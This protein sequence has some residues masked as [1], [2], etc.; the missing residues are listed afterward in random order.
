MRPVTPPLPA[1][2]LALSLLAVPATA[3][4]TGSA[5]STT[6]S[7]HLTL[8]GQ[9]LL[10]PPAPAASPLLPTL[11]G[12]S[13]LPGF[14]GTD[15]ALPM[16]LDGGSKGWRTIQ[17]VCADDGAAI[18]TVYVFNE[19]IGTYQ[20]GIEYWYVARSNLTRIGSVGLVIS[21]TDTDSRTAP[22]DPGYSPEQKFQQVQNPSGG[23]GAG[24]T[25]DPVSGGYL[26]SGPSNYNVRFKLSTSTPPTVTYVTWYQVLASGSPANIDPAGSWTVD[27]LGSVSVPSGS[28][29]YDINQS[30][31]G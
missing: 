1:T 6:L 2:L 31:G 19:I 26:Y 12:S 16:Q 5:E 10:P 3:H 9:S 22:S 30:Y 13:A 14:G 17:M 23:W 24:W 4:A 7:P 28:T 8:T 29:G 15:K 20:P 18:A 11:S 27:S 25:T 21:V